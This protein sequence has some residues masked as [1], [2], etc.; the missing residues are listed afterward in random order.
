MDYRE[1]AEALE[2]QDARKRIADGVAALFDEQNERQ[3]R[4]FYDP[5]SRVQWESKGRM[6]ARGKW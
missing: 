1:M 3:Y 2:R 6:P 4:R 5:Q